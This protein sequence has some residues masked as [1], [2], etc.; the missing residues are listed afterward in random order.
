[1]HWGE[2]GCESRCAL[3]YTG[4]LEEGCKRGHVMC[5]IRHLYRDVYTRIQG[6]L[7]WALAKAARGLWVPA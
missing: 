4:V 2:A 1:M 6:A 3:Q 7:G 5:F